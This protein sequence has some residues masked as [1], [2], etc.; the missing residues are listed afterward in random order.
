VE[1]E[2]RSGR[3]APVNATKNVDR[4]GAYIR[5]DRRLTIRII[6]DELNINECTDHQNVTQDLNM[7]KLC[8]KMLPKKLNDDQKARRNEV[9][10]EMLDRLET[11]PDFLN[12]VTTGYES[13]VFEYDPQTERESEE[14][15]TPHSPRHEQ[16][17]TMVI[18]FS[19]HSLGVVCVEFS[20]PGVTVNKKY[21]LESLDRLRKRVM[22][23]RKEI[24]DDWI[25]QSSSRQRARMH[26]IVS[27]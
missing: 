16:M 24:A 12:R 6:A 22:R 8:A 11:E 17:K 25:P 10:A 15:H 5:Q 21:Y 13:L 7:R 18:R 9:S 19:P 26:S 27:S 3:P 2:P 1:D 14:I 23:V 4:V 20:P